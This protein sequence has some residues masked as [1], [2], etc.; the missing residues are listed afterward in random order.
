MH[1]DHVNKNDLAGRIGIGLT[2]LI[3]IG[4]ELLTLQRA[5]AD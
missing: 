3:V 5:L 4:V 2:L 1:N